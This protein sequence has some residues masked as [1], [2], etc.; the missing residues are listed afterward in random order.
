M[1]TNTKIKKYRDG[2]LLI[3]KQSQCSYQ[4]KIYLG[5]SNGQTRFTYKSI[6]WWNPICGNFCKITKYYCENYCVY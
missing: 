1:T 4:G 2:E 3:L 5:R 6:K